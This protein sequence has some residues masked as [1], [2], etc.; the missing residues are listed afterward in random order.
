MSSSAHTLPVLG[1]CAQTSNSGKTTLICALIPL[2]A[3]M[4]IRVSVVKHTHHAFDIDYPGKDS[5]KIRQ[6]GA[7]QTLVGNASTWAIISHQAQPRAE[8][9]ELDY[10]VQQFDPHMTDLILV[11]GFRHQAIPKIE[12][13]RTALHTTALAM[14]DPYVIAVAS[15]ASREQGLDNIPCPLLAL[16]QTSSIAQWIVQYFDLCAK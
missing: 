11:E 8:A 16:N 2:M 6:A 13:F 14:Q 12:I 9:S 4:G 1:I 5:S 7:V 3:Q 10:L 15:D